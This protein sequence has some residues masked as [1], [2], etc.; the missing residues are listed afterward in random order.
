MRGQ[1]SPSRG[2]FIAPL[3]A[4]AIGFDHARF[5]RFSSPLHVGSSVGTCHPAD[6]LF[7]SISSP[8]GYRI[9]RRLCA[10]RAFVGGLCNC[11]SMPSTGSGPTFG[12]FWS[13]AGHS[14]GAG[15][16]YRGDGRVRHGAGCLDLPRLPDGA[17]CDRPNLRRGTCSDP[18]HDQPRSGCG[19]VRLSGDGVGYCAHARPHGR[20]A[21]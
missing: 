19:Q 18:R 15:D 20:W 16:I 2:L 4:Q 12:P 11:V 8:N 9:W 10:D 21:A 14:R 3:P 7:P 6:Q 5:I 13:S 17:G 1:I